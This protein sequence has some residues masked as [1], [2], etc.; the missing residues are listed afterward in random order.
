MCMHIIYTFGPV[1]N[2]TILNSVGNSSTVY[3]LKVFKY[4]NVRTIIIN[5][6]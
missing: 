4:D 6:A 1:T 5:V 2:L 3:K